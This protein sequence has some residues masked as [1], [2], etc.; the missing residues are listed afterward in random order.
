MHGNIICCY[1]ESLSFNCIDAKEVM[2]Q[3]LVDDGS[4][5]KGQR[6]SIFKED[7]N[8]MSCYSGDHSDFH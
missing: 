8:V 1:G 3:M 5:S 7:F 2:L 4:K 6:G